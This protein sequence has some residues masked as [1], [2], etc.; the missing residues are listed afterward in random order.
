MLVYEDS[1][2]LTYSIT[3]DGAAAVQIE[4]E[5]GLPLSGFVQSMDD[6]R[7]LLDDSLKR[8]NPPHANSMFCDYS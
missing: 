4:G 7:F 5:G 6:N 2:V 1:N 8:V 3:D